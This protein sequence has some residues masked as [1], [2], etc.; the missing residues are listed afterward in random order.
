MAT[1]EAMYSLLEEYIEK[2]NERPPVG[3]EYKGVCLGGWVRQQKRK[4]RH[5]QLTEEQEAALEKFSR[6]LNLDLSDDWFRRYKITEDYLLQN[7]KLPSIKTT[8]KGLRAGVW[9]N[10]QLNSKDKLNAKQRELILGLKARA[11]NMSNPGVSAKIKLLKEYILK[12]NH[13]PEIKEQYNGTAIGKVYSETHHKLMSNKLNKYELAELREVIDYIKIS[14]KDRKW[15][16]SFAVFKDFLQE[17]NGR[18]PNYNEVYKGEFIGRWYRT[19]RHRNRHGLLAPETRIKFE[20][21]CSEYSL[22]L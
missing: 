17:N 22:E 20:N 7:R 2:Y 18:I 3:K 16:C 21:I 14:P 11:D 5:K 15:H 9:F 13:L 12:F 6:Y 4:F 19:Q 10:N 8:H 1:W